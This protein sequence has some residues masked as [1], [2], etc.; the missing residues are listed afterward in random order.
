MLDTRSYRGPNA[1]NMEESYGPAAY[2]FAPQQI[3]WLKRS[4]ARSQADLEGHCM[5][6]AA[7]ADAAL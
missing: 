3:A 4:L 5:R 1:A 7:G 2:F 6:H